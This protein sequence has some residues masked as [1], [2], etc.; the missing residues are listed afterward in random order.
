MARARTTDNRFDLRGGVNTQM[1][2]DLLDSTE[3][4][5]ALNARQYVLG[6][7]QKRGGTQRLQLTAIDGGAEVT[8][9]A[10]W[11]PA[12]RE[13][14]ALASGNLY[15]KALDDVDFTEVAGA[16]STTEYARFATWR[17]GS[18]ILLLFAD[19]QFRTWDGSTLVEEI[20]DAPAALD[21]AVYKGRVFAIDGTK[22]LYGT[23]LRNY[24]AWAAG[25]GGVFQDIETYDA[26]GIIAIAKAGSSL[27]I[28]KE[29]SIARWTGVSEDEIRID[30]ETEG[31]SPIVGCRSRRTFI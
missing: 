8:G 22:R 6:G 27:L 3:L 4:R 26:E 7:Y 15:Y 17:D 2:D 10:L 5:R 31:V 11:R 30:V 16:L 29:N 25:D 12:A 18:D 19:G 21:V 24:E 9:V 13:L 1:T 28:A 14:V 23:A 20:T